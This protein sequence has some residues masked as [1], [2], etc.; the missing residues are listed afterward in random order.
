[1]NELVKKKKVVDT[2]KKDMRQSFDAS[3]SLALC[4]LMGSLLSSLRSIPKALV[5]NLFIIY[6]I[7]MVDL[8]S[9]DKEFLLL[10]CSR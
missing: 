3:S 7:K 9:M 10:L 8:V 1:M 4:L 2:L 6:V 5:P